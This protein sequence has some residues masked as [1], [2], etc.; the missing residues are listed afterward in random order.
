MI[1]F[2]IENDVTTHEEAVQIALEIER[3]EAALKQLKEQLKEYVS[4]NGPV[5]TGDKVWEIREYPRWVFSPEG[6]QKLCQD[7]VIEGKNP[8][9]FLSLFLSL[10][11]TALNKLGW[12]ESVIEEYGK[13]KTTSRFD[14]YKKK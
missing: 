2:V 4:K 3:L 10:S 9:E 8:W 11:S 13:K 12:N 5:D 14:S 7:M 1:D 6:L